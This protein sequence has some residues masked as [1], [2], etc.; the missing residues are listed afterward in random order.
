MAVIILI[1][2][3]IGILLLAVLILLILLLSAALFVPVRYELRGN[4]QDR[5]RMR[6][7]V[8]WFLH[9]LSL[10]F[11]YEGKGV[12]CDVRIFGIKK[13]EKP[14]GETGQKEEKNRGR[15]FGAGRR[16]RQTAAADGE[17]TMSA[18]GNP[19]E[20]DDERK[21]ADGD[22]A[23]PDD[24]RENA[25]ETVSQKAESRD[26]ADTEA[27]VAGE[28]ALSGDDGE[29]RPRRTVGDGGQEADEMNSSGGDI[30]KKRASGGIFRRLRD[31]VVRVTDAVMR[32]PE[33]LAQ[34]GQKLTELKGK[35]LDE[36]NKIAVARIWKELV[37]LLR[38]FRF[39]RIRSE[40]TFSLGDPALT[41]QALG[42][43][44][45]LPFLYRYETGVFPDFESDRW[46]VRG[47]VSAKGHAHLVHLLVSIVRLW[48]RKE[49]RI[50]VKRFM[51]TMRA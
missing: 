32:I 49:L 26:A 1:L 4:F 35:V 29:E 24:G 34:S 46:Y 38:H 37:Y 47:T 13:K 10:W 14:D 23:E 19:A 42:L 11:A 44:A 43:L 6:V 33:S 17:E 7:H 15:R 5:Y 9:A 8:H 30:Q 41:G 16:G 12:T 18:D 22:P 36:T 28:Y 20:P 21:M 45:M 25:A 39:R 31:L 2:K 40:L 3:A 27:E 51:Q 48:R 50:F